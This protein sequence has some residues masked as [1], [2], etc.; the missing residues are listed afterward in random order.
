MYRQHKSTV[1]QRGRPQSSFYIGYKRNRP[2]PRG[3]REQGNRAAQWG[4]Q[5]KKVQKGRAEGQKGVHSGIFN[6]QAKEN[7]APK[8]RSTRDRGE[9]CKK[10]K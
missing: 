8:G 9:K 3:E 2:I 4:T 5:Q 6:R 1:N 7:K 10:P